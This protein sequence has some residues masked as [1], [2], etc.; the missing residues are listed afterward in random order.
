[1]IVL[2]SV[3]LAGLVAPSA[4]A[5]LTG[6][7]STEPK[8]APD[9][10]PADEVRWQ[11]LPTG[12]R[13]AFQQ[14]TGGPR[15]LSVKAAQ[16]SSG[17]YRTVSTSNSVRVVP[18]EAQPYLISGKVTPDLFDIGALVGEAQPTLVVRRK[19]GTV[20][21][22]QI[23]ADPQVAGDLWTKLTG[24]PPHA[25]LTDPN[26]QLADGIRRVALAGKQPTTHASSQDSGCS[27][28]SNPNEP[29]PGKFPVT[30]K[31]LDRR[32]DPAW[33]TF[34]LRDYHCRPWELNGFIQFRTQPGAA[35]T[36]YVRKSTYSLLGDVR[37]YDASGRQVVEETIGGDTQLEVDG[38]TDVVVDA[39]DAVQ[40]EFDTSRKSELAH[41]VF[42]WTRGAAG[43]RLAS[44]LVLTPQYSA[45][46]RVSLIP[47]GPVTDGEF[48][49]YPSVRLTAPLAEGTVHGGGWSSQLDAKLLTS[50]AASNLDTTLRVRHA[51]Q[52]CHGCALVVTP[53]PQTG[54]PGAVK[55]AV[56]AGA[57]AVLVMPSQPGVVHQLLSADI[58]VLAVSYQQGMQ[59]RRRLSTGSRHANVTLTLKLRPQSP[60]L[61]D[62]AFDQHA[63]PSDASYEI[64]ADDVT[65][66]HQRFASDGTATR[67][68][69]TRYTVKPCQCSLTPIFGAIELGT[70]RLD[71]VSSNDSAWQQMVKVPGSV[72]ARDAPHAYD[73]QT[74]PTN[75]WFGGPLAPAL[76]RN[77]PL[78]DWLFPAYTSNGDLVFHIGSSVDNAGHYG[79]GGDHSGRVWLNGEPLGDFDGFRTI[80]A[81]DRSGTWR[82]ELQ[83]TRPETGWARSTRARTVWTFDAAAAQ[84]SDR[85]PL[86]MVDARISLPVQ[87]DGHPDPGGKVVIQPWRLDADAIDVEQIS[88]DLS[89]DGGET[90]LPQPLSDT[91]HGYTATPVLPGHGPVAMRVSIEA[92]DGST[93]H[94]TVR[95][96]WVR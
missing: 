44:A 82:L 29:G 68:Y 35:E 70:T 48:G 37:T 17:R 14:T 39:R 85:Q 6:S 75:E 91:A 7:V 24:Q 22:V 55:G 60:Y 11:T 38:P 40:L 72:T 64:N 10:K 80:D 43:H 89:V 74:P 59:L 9:A 36:F 16:G 71:Y 28:D 49:F 34:I 46:Q 76:T 1:M 51:G 19:T 52:D 25:T 31:A 93:M 30:I 20:R 27:D 23:P 26:P 62:L 41:A 8:P 42:G 66:V 86:P 53:D 58:P 65:L 50:L 67:A 21:R 45:L 79:Y 15:V 3:V 47:T 96:A 32:G 4:Q 57:A 12:D 95:R 69:E 61:Y 83:T 18:A 94:R 90:W 73:E 92:A 78:G 77:R 2:L 88:L 5:N 56:D 33:G 63:I 84:T 13:V 81:Q 87:L 54:I